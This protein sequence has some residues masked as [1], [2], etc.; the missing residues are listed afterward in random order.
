MRS[1]GRGVFFI[2]V[3]LVQSDLEV[4][5]NLSLSMSLSLSFSL[6]LYLNRFDI[7]ALGA[8]KLKVLLKKLGLCKRKRLDTLDNNIQKITIPP[9]NEDLKSMCFRCIIYEIYENVWFYIK[10]VILFSSMTLSL[11]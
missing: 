2:T 8:V 4:K 5:L 3:L 1:C 9:Q 10:K 7:D 11:P 6:S